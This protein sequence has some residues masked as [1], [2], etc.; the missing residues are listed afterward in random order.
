M[1]LLIVLID[2]LDCGL[3]SRFYMNKVS[4]FL[5]ATEREKSDENYASLPIKD[6]LDNGVT[7]GSFLH[8]L[9]IN[10][11]PSGCWNITES[12]STPEAMRSISPPIVMNSEIYFKDDQFSHG[13]W[14]N[15]VDEIFHETASV[16]IHNL[17]GAEA[18]LASKKTNVGIVRMMELAHA[19]KYIAAAET[20]ARAIYNLMMG[21][22]L[23]F[24]NSMSPAGYIIA[25]DCG[26]CKVALDVADCVSCGLLYKLY[27]IDEQ[28]GVKKYITGHAYNPGTII[29]TY[30]VTGISLAD[31]IKG[32]MGLKVVD[33]AKRVISDDEMILRHLEGFGYM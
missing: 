1:D 13:R 8:K 7:I 18:A 29:S 21:E 2:G 32:M 17:H 19:M 4:S 16:I 15:K 3:V 26:I 23:K 5:T 14:D 11:L 30:K 24:I 22:V 25:S 6:L 9:P 31:M 33:G 28:D 10:R 20:K 27:K 12:G